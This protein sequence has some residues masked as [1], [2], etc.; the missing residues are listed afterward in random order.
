LNHLPDWLGFA[1]WVR[2]PPA[3]RLMP[4]IVS[5]GCSS[6]WNTPWLAWLPELGCT[7]A[8]AAAE[9]RLGPVDGE[10]LGDVDELAAAIVAAARIA[11]GIFV[12][13]HRALRLHHGGGDDVLR[14]DQLDLV[15]LAAEFL[16]DGAE[17]LGIAAFQASVKK[18]SS[19]CGAFMVYGIPAQRERV[20]S[21][22]W[23]PWAA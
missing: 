20:E 10:V 7:L 1:P 5:P 19:R 18:P 15:A 21:G 8:K 16:F 14:R 22:G 17:N 13:H 4:R 11:F 9:Q 12:G 23:A 6:A 3:S 2:C